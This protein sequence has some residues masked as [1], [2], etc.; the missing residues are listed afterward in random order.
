MPFV[1]L[2]LQLL[3]LS[4]VRCV[5]ARGAVVCAGTVASFFSFSGAA[6]S[7]GGGGVLGGGCFGIVLVGS[8]YSTSSIGA[9]KVAFW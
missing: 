8:G 1:R 7:G 6:V 4:G 3:L 5:G 9:M 2:E